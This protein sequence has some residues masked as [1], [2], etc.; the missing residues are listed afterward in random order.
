VQRPTPAIVSLSLFWLSLS[1]LVAGCGGGGGK[2]KVETPTT[3]KGMFDAL[4]IDTTSTPRTYVD[5]DGRTQTLANGYNPLGSGVR[6]LH[7]LSELYIAGR[8]I[9]GAHANQMLLDDFKH[10][11]TTIAAPPNPLAVDDHAET[12]LTNVDTA[13]IPADLDGDGNDEIVNLYWIEASHELH[14]NVLRCAGNCAGNGGNFAPV[15]DSLLTVKDPT[16]KPYDRYWFKHGFAAADVD[17]DGK[18][19]IVAVNF[20]GI[21]VCKPAADFSLACTMKVANPSPFMSVARGRFDDVPDKANDDVAVVFSNAASTL[22]YLAI[23]DGAPDAFAASATANGHDPIPLSL[24]FADQPMVWQYQDAYVTAGDIDNDGRDEILIS[25]H[26]YEPGDPKHHDLFL[27][28]DRRTSYRFFTAFR[29]FLGTGSGRPDDGDN[30]RW[31]PPLQ[32]F[33]KRTKPALERAIYAGSDIID[34]LQHIMPSTTT[35]LPSGTAIDNGVTGI[36]MS[37]YED[38]GG[39]YNHAPP[40]V[41]IGDVDG[42]ENGTAAILAVWDQVNEEIHN[43]D[44]FVPATIARCGWD[45]QLGQ[46]TRWKDIITTTS[47]NTN[48]VG[49]N[50]DDGNYPVTLAMPN[51]DRDSPVVKYNGQHELL[52]G[53]PRILAVLAAP[54]FIDKVNGQNGQTGISFGTGLGFGSQ[55]TIGVNAGFSIGYEAPSLFG[56]TTLSWKLSF[57]ASLDWISSSN[58]ALDQTETWTTSTDDA[59]VFQVIPFDVYYYTV[60]SSPDPADVGNTLSINVPRKISTYK[61]PVSLYNASVVDGPQIDSAIL[62]HTIGDPASYPKYNA[63]AA[64]PPGGSFG[65]TSYLVD[66]NSWCYASATPLHVG[67]GSG[68][69]GFTIARTDT[70]STGISTDLSVEF[71]QEVGAGGFTAGTSVGFHW[72]YEYTVDTSQSYSFDGQVG[73]LPDA[74]R[75]YDFGLMAHKGMLAGRIDYPA[76]LVDYWVENVQ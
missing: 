70:S 39:S 6:T 65:A 76:F 47:G 46:W 10:A 59:V 55:G 66:P 54:P 37:Y 20:G 44:A 25:G 43:K 3:D 63:C 19:E 67:V 45:P 51:V 2:P 60:V 56:L 42:N 32:V 38:G 41:A 29:W 12:W 40:E 22:A 74:K 7:A 35:T 50:G 30:D 52:F 31:R 27:I 23:Y 36:R 18:Q 69:V 24:L 1:N 11:P 58:V 73:D 26:R 68:T 48:V 4:G 9:G 57:N 28:D 13:S 33:T 16:Q 17:G 49:E 71:E 15:K 14:A 8:G 5:H 53:L 75:G 72:G 64:A 21:H 34:G 62:T 61:V